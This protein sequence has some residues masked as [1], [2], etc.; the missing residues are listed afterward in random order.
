MSDNLNL[1]DA[2]NHALDPNNWT[3][4][5]SVVEIEGLVGPSFKRF[6]NTLVASPC[7]KSYLE[8]GTWEGSSTVSAL[9]G[10]TQKL[11]NYWAIDNWHE[12]FTPEHKTGQRG[13]TKNWNNH[14]GA[15][16]PTNFINADSFAIDPIAQGI[17]AVDVY[18]YDGSHE[19][20]H[21]TQALTHYIACMSPVFVY[22][23]DDWKWDHVRRGA[24][25]GIRQT[26][27][28][29]LHRIEIEGK[30]PGFENATEGWGNGTGIFVLEKVTQ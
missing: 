19:E 14:I 10:N 22:A 18:F 20:K 2:V 6:I 25:E 11:N 15:S 29:I 21:Q 13:F 8:I 23:V 24:L 7:V 16:V 4:P 27:V 12:W 17:R 1:I 3:L 26:G 9:Y 28:K 30:G 5:D